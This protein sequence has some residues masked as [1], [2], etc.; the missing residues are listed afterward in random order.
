MTNNIE[1]ENNF[2]VR[3]LRSKEKFIV[4]DKFLNGYARFLGIYAVGVYTSLCRHANKQ[5]KSWPSIKKISQELNISRNK[6][7]E[8]VKYL[9]FWKIVKKKRVGKQLTNR[10]FLIDKKQ[11][12]PLSETH[13]RDFSEVHNINFTSLRDKL[14][15]F[16]T[17]TSNRKETQEKGNTIEKEEPFSLKEKLKIMFEDP[18]HHIRI[19]ALYW[20]FKKIKI[21]NHDQYQAFIKRD[22]TAAKELVGFSNEQIIKVMEYLEVNETFKWNIF[23]LIKYLGENLDRIKPIN[24]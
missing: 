8:S 11:W 14:H 18:K 9:E 17:R 13:V 12:K 16:T 24:Q 5:Q 10:Y 22:A 15:E 2:E 1:E 4:D 21:D 23:T 19:V 3:D 7:I 20:D 6:I